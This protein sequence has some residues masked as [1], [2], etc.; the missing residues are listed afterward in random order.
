MGLQCAVC[1]HLSMALVDGLHYNHVFVTGGKRVKR[2]VG[3]RQSVESFDFFYIKA[4][5]LVVIRHTAFPNR[6]KRI[7]H[8]CM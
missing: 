8:I 1:F 4:A 6:I 3:L 7:E 5:V 2:E